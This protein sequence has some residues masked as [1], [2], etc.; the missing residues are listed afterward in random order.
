MTFHR[1]MRAACGAADTGSG[2][3]GTGRREGEG[4]EDQGVQGSPQSHRSC[5]AST[6]AARSSRRVLSC[7]QGSGCGDTAS[8]VGGGD[9]STDPAAPQHCL[10]PCPAGSPLGPEK[11]EEE[12]RPPSGGAVRAARSQ[13]PRMRMGNGASEHGI[14][15]WLRP[16]PPACGLAGAGG[17]GCRGG[18][19]HKASETL[20][21]DAG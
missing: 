15:V 10:S 7:C 19:S 18:S 8:S 5:W 4:A 6:P 12:R 13:E 9:R 2:G 11:P 21:R 17:R 16:P 1:V 20:G 3:A 14:Q